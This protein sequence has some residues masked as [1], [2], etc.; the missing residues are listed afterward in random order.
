MAKL[1]EIQETHSG[2]HTLKLR[3]DPDGLQVEVYETTIATPDWVDA[4]L[5]V[6]L[7]APIAGIGWD[8]PEETDNWRIETSAEVLR[9][10]HNGVRAWLD[11]KQV[12]TKLVLEAFSR[13]LLAALESAIAAT[14]QVEHTTTKGYQND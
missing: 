6:P 7:I 11:G 4:P 12:H 8:I 14:G 10:T 1:T 2:G 5:L 3:Y 9:I 13:G